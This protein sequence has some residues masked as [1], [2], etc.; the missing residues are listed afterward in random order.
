MSLFSNLGW[1]LVFAASWIIPLL[2]DA[3]QPSWL[4]YFSSLVI[5]LIPITYLWANI[6]R[7]TDPGARRRKA[8]AIAIVTVVVL[9]GVLDFILGN[10]TLIFNSKYVWCIRGVPIEEMLFYSLAPTAIALAYAC[11]DQIWFH[12]P[13]LENVRHSFRP[14]DRLL[15]IHGG[16]A[17]TAVLL[18]AIAVTVGLR[19][20]IF[21]I[22]F[23]F[24]IAFA[25]LPAVFLYG[26]LRRVINWHA[27]AV[28]TF[29]VIATSMF[30]ELTL[31]LPRGWWGYQM[32]GMLARVPAW[33]GNA[34]FPIEA[35]IV[36]VFAPFTCVMAFEF[37]RALIY[38]PARTVRGALFGAAE[39]KR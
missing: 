37:A 26:V 30:W 1:L 14:C 10:K 33:S 17:L 21:P 38:H 39:P 25:I 20:H 22:Y 6:V 19:R 3:H 9:G 27:F 36:W 28:T 16:F 23:T 18:T 12:S 5:W 31:A 24:L 35:A 7:A 32:H 29:Y 15:S 34:P 4:T 2:L 8:L 13:D 11:C